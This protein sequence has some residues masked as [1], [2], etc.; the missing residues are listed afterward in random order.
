[1]RNE[2]RGNFHVRVM[3][4]RE[5]TLDRAKGGGVPEEVAKY[6]EESRPARSFNIEYSPMIHVHAHTATHE[7][8]H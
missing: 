5:K 8:I 1:M 2:G 3:L 4:G 7:H 6:N